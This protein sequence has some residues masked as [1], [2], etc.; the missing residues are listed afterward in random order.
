VADR[1]ALIIAVDVAGAAPH[2]VTF[3]ERALEG[4]FFPEQPERLIDD[5]ACDSDEFAANLAEQ[6]TERTVP[7]RARRCVPHQDGRRLR[8]HRACWR[9]ERLSAWLHDLSCDLATFRAR[10]ETPAAAEPEC[11]GSRRLGVAALT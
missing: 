10:R 7:R 4:G 1:S 5:E 9:V 6:G 8:R 2:E 3:V 11:M